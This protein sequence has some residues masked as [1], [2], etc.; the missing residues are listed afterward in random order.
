MPE[1][2]SQALEPAFLSGVCEANEATIGMPCKTCAFSD[3][4]LTGRPPP[5]SRRRGPLLCLRHC[6]RVLKSKMF[7]LEGLKMKSEET[8]LLK[9][10]WPS[11]DEGCLLFFQAF[12]KHNALMPRASCHP[13]VKHCLSASRPPIKGF[14]SLLLVSAIRARVRSLSKHRPCKFSVPRSLCPRYTHCY[15]REDTHTVT[16]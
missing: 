12:P 1:D 4:G 5:H 16:H 9:P 7:Q 8:S 10:R 13:P 14:P 2:H 11:N 15:T 6:Q 3:I